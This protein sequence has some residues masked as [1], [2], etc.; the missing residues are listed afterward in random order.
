MN[1]AYK[2]ALAGLGHVADFQIEALKDLPQ[3]D[4]CGAFDIDK[5]KKTK[6]GRVIPFFTDLKEMLETCQPDVVLVSVP[7]QVHAK[8][9]ITVIDAGVNVLVEKPPATNMDDFDIV[10]ER[11]NL[12]GVLFHTAF[13]AS[14]ALD[15]I[16]YLNNRVSIEQQQGPIKS[17]FC[18]FYDP[19]I[20]DQGLKLAAKNLQGSWI[21]SGINALSVIDQLV[22]NLFLR[23]SRMTMVNSLHC[24]QIQGTADF[25][26]D[27]QGDQCCGF[28]QIDTNWTLGINRKQTILFHE[29]RGCQTLLN[30]TEQAVYSTG[31]QGNVKQLY[32]A[33]KNKMRLTAH[34]EGVFRDLLI[35]LK[36]GKDNRKQSR[37]LLSFLLEAARK[38]LTCS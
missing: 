12:K 32:K 18:G 2:I 4:F 30:H 24:D 37:Q 26:F 13:H 3:L 6:V 31:P 20:T 5:K 33:E 25:S 36:T 19:Y 35:S 9:S 15:L 21:D 29:K 10:S 11:A 8:T 34:Y 23:E 38:G 7:N 1:K 22:E 17:F 14:F 16:W 28:G 27:I